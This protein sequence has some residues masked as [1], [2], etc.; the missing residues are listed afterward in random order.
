MSGCFGVD[1]FF[2]KKVV[3]F[4]KEIRLQFRQGLSLDKI[5]AA[6]A[7]FIQTETTDS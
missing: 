6:T 2:A 5:E 3:G 1:A 7:P 4:L